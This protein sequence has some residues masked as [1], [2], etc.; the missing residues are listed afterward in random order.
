M[1][2]GATVSKLTQPPSRSAQEKSSAGANRR[3]FSPPGEVCGLESDAEDDTGLDVGFV[4][5]V[6][7]LEK[8]RGGDVAAAKTP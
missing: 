5:D 4:R 8:R 3:D 7:A 2:G 1:T 6:G